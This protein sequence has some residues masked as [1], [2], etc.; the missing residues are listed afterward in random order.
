MNRLKEYIFITSLLLL[1]SIGFYEVS[2]STLSYYA[3]SSPIYFTDDFGATN[4]IYLKSIH[5]VT[6]TS[7]GS[8]QFPMDVT[9]HNVQLNFLKLMN[10]YDFY[11]SDLMDHMYL[12]QLYLKIYTFNETDVYNYTADNI[13][14]VSRGCT[15]SPA[16]R[17]LERTL[18]D[19]SQVWYEVQMD[20]AHPLLSTGSGYML[21]Y[22]FD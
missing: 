16:Y 17:Y 1:I 6:Y 12:K 9:S 10:T 19:Y 14:G 11:L 20:P 4:A 2:A 7:L 13:Y 3:E 15:L 5:S 21:R 22:I 18:T 8:P